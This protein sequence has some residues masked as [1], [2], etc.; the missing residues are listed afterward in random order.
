VVLSPDGKLVATGSDGDT[1]R[2]WDAGTGKLIRTVD[3]PALGAEVRYVR[4]QAFSPDG[5]TLVVCS[6]LTLLFYDAA[7]GKLAPERCPVRQ[8]GHHAAFSPDGGRPAVAGRGGVRVWSFAEGEKLF[9]YLIPHSSE[10]LRGT[11]WRVAFAPDG[12]HLAARVE[13]P[14]SHKADPDLVPPVLVWDLATK[15]EVFS[16]PEGI[17]GSFSADRRFLTV[18][19]GKGMKVYEW[20][21]KELRANFETGSGS[22]FVAILAPDGRAVFTGGG[23]PEVRRWEFPSGKPAGVLRGRD[24]PTY[25]AA[26]SRDGKVLAG[27]DE[28]NRVLI[29]HLGAE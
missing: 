24:G 12:R 11:A 2:F 8:G 25:P 29:W 17:L 21:K 9:E 16:T 28:A 23:G 5:R 20:R 10:G 6:G 15:E 26:F 13:G 3:V 27:I 18:L 22:R 14:K 7:T 1:L 4:A 19:E